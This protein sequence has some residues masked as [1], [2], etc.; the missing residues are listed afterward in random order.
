MDRLQ[1]RLG[2]P[3]LSAVIV[4]VLGT[5]FVAGL[6]NTGRWGWPIIAYPMYAPPRYEN[7]RVL[8]DVSV[9]AEL[10]DGTRL[11]ITREQLG[12][13]F[14]VFEENVVQSI[15]HLDDRCRATGQPVPRFCIAGRAGADRFRALLTPLTARLCTETGGR[16]KRLAYEDLGVAVTRAGPAFDLKP[17]MQASFEVTCQ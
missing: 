13:P 2:I 15:R 6:I 4:V 16:L 9:Y 1:E 11:P 3:F 5:Q 17:V 12:M 7:E 14:W 10:E 8:Y